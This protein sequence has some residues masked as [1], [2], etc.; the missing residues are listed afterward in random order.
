MPRLGQVVRCR[1]CL[2]EIVFVLTAK[3]ALMPLDA[4]PATV[5][6]IDVGDGAL[7]A[8]TP[9]ARRIAETEQVHLPHF[10]SCP[11][12]GAWRHRGEPEVEE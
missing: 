9:R 1:S 2:R 4:R 6:A 7:D 5:Y 3:G 11:Q 12:V 8:A 10:A